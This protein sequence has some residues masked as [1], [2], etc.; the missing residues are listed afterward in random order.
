MESRVASRSVIYTRV[1]LM[2][3][4]RRPCQ[5][6]L[7]LFQILDQQPVLVMKKKALFITA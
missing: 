3:A 4:V 7:Q 6:D 1:L 2:V 5:L